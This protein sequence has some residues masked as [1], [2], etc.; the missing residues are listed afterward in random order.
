LV[1]HIEGEHRLREAENRVPRKI[2]W[3]Q[4]DE[5]A[6]EYGRLFKEELYDLYCSLNINGAIKSRKRAGHV[7]CIRERTVTFRVL[8]G[9][10]E[11]KRPLARGTLR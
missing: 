11:G 4:R 6:A 2:F 9:K 7:A 3:P 1:S 5:G 10:P 8:V